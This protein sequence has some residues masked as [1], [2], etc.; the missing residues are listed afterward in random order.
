MGFVVVSAGSFAEECVSVALAQAA[1]ALGVLTGVVTEVNRWQ[2]TPGYGR[3][4]RR[5]T[6]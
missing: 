5:R 6:P 3:H 1:A 2:W 4:G